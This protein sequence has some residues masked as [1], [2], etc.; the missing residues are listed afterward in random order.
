MTNSH[1]HTHVVHPEAKT[2][3]NGKQGA[4]PASSCAVMLP[5]CTRTQELF[6]NRIWK[7]FHCS[8]TGPTRKLKKCSFF[9]ASLQSAG[10]PPVLCSSYSH[11]L[12]HINSIDFIL[13][14]NDLVVGMVN[15][16]HFQCIAAFFQHLSKRFPKASSPIYTPVGGF[17]NARCH[18]VPSSPIVKT[19][20]QM[21]RDFKHQPFGHWTIHSTKHI[22]P[23]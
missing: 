19:Q 13:L 17:R 16:L 15:W 5:S 11:K 23:F 10:Q 14:Y 3:A 4:L 18:R 7:L 1:L 22:S 9:F 21:N 20:R 2:K 8:P 12:I 6:C